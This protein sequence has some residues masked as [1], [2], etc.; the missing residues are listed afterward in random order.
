MLQQTSS[1]MTGQMGRLG[2]RD[3]AMWKMREDN[4][5]LMVVKKNICLMHHHHIIGNE[6]QNRMSSFSSQAERDR[7]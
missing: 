4:I 1:T 2:P 5:F 3:V 6:T 7:E